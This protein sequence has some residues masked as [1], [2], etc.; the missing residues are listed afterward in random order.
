LVDYWYDYDNGYTTLT[1]GQALTRG[2]LSLIGKMRVKDDV[3]GR[4]TT[5]IISIPK[6][7]LMSDLS[8]RVGSD[9]IP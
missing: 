7:R 9:A 6:L 3:T 2:Y 1:I 5:G 8:I 4:V